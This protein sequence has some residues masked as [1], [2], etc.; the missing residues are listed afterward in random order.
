MSSI[1]Q[2]LIQFRRCKTAVALFDKLPK[3]WNLVLIAAK[4]SDVFKKEWQ[5]L[6]CENAG[7]R[8]YVATYIQLAK[9]LQAI[10]AS[11]KRSFSNLGKLLTRDR[12]FKG[13]NVRLYM[14]LKYNTAVILYQSWNQVGFG[15]WLAK[16]F[17]LNSGFDFH[18]SYWYS[19][20]KY[21]K[22]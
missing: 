21:G 10:S 12:N 15:L 8:W 22:N 11:V 2:L 5:Q 1:V 4:L 18:F 7:T 20:K 13:N 17:G 16:L 9:Q 3:K 14:M 6:H 19:F